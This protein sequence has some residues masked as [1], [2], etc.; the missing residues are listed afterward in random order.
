MLIFLYSVICS[1]NPKNSVSNLFA[2]QKDKLPE[3][4]LIKAFFKSFKILK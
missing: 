3:N 1:S 4:K 2:L